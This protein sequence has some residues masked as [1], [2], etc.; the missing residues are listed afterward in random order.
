MKRTL[1]ILKF[2]FTAALLLGVEVFLI[3]TVIA[4]NSR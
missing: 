1:L 4:H 3:V 2:V